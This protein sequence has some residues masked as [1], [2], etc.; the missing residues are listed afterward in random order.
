[1]QFLFKASKN[2]DEI[3]INPFKLGVVLVTLSR[4]IRTAR[5]IMDGCGQFSYFLLATVCL[6]SILNTFSHCVL[7]FEYFYHDF[8]D[9]DEFR[10][11]G[12]GNKVKV[13]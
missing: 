13:T 4:C 11:F 1:M 8:F 3:Y 9:T 7:Y 5:L 12:T 10:F 2:N 6:Y